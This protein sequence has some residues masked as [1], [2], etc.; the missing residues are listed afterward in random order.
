MARIVAVANQKGGV[1]KTTTTVNVA[2]A[3]GL[4]GQKTLVIDIDPQGNATQAMGIRRDGD[5][6]T[7]YDVLLDGTP[8]IDAIQPTSDP[9]V[10]CI[11]ASVDLAGAEV[12]LVGLPDRESQL[13]R[14]LDSLLASTQPD[15]PDDGIR[16]V[17]AFDVVLI[18]CPPSL[19]LLTI[20]ALAA[21]H[22]LFV[23]LQAEFYALD[24]VGQLVRTVELVRSA[25][26]PELQI[27]FVALT[28]V[29]D[30]GPGQQFVV[31]EARAF[32]GDNLAR[33]MIPRDPALSA[34]PSEGKTILSYAPSSPGAI[35]YCRLAEELRDLALMRQ[36]E[37]KGQIE[38]GVR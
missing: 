26:N 4:L 27:S 29:G 13:A 24:G 28:M 31:D 18:D 6:V 30:D 23:P 14:A 38:V 25:L 16:G 22:E 34:A 37:H 8:A 3:L 7:V 10:W 21:A 36:S 17:E 2:A 20:N 9:G 32:F 33:T 12:E 1:G 11:P 19:G 35:A 5:T 15:A